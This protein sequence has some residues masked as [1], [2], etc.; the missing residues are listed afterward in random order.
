MAITTDLAFKIPT[1]VIIDDNI[2]TQPKGHSML[3][4]RFHSGDT[5]PSALKIWTTLI[6]TPIHPREG[7]TEDQIRYRMFIYLQLTSKFKIAVRYC[8]DVI[9]N[10]K[11]ALASILL[12]STPLASCKESDFSDLSVLSP[13]FP[14]WV[15]PELYT[16]Y[17]LTK[18]LCMKLR[19]ESLLQTLFDRTALLSEESKH[20]MVDYGDVPGLTAYKLFNSDQMDEMLPYITISYDRTPRPV[21]SKTEM[22][23]SIRDQ[24]MQ[25]IEV[26]DNFIIPE[27]A[28][29]TI[30]Y[31]ILRTPDA[32]L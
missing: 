23:L 12:S 14:H 17:Y 11:A 13:S 4:F 31:F 2:P 15:S 20:I 25:S 26:S 9:G 32:S 22:H 16:P 3:I 18:M 29:T 19:D 21:M 8:N 5:K 24:L 10:P 30:P 6:D 27:N 28:K 7:F 1:T